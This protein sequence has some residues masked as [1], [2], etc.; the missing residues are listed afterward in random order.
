[1]PTHSPV[2]APLLLLVYYRHRGF[3]T[4]WVNSPR[5][6]ARAITPNVLFYASRCTNLHNL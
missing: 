6:P 4:G 2:P 1:L 5:H 3:R